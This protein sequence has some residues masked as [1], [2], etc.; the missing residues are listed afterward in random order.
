[1]KMVLVIYDAGIDEDLR[2]SSQPAVDCAARRAGEQAHHGAGRAQE[3]V[4]ETSRP[5]GVRLPGGG[6]LDYLRCRY[7]SQN[8]T[9]VAA[10]HRC[11]SAD[12]ALAATSSRK[13]P[14]NCSR[15]QN[16]TQAS[17]GIL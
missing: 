8:A 1:M 14:R 15:I 12:T 17:A 11:A 9:P 7:M 3:V 16:P 6:Q 5:A 2:G 10:P 13:T 4:P